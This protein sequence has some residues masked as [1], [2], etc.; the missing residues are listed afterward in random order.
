MNREHT[1]NANPL[2]AWPGHTGNWGRWPNDRGTLNL[3]TPEV[4]LRGIGCAR[5]GEVIHCARPTLPVGSI[6]SLDLFEQTMTHVRE[7]ADDCSVRTISAADKLT[8]RVHN[9]DNTH[10]D[11]L[12]HIGFNGRNFNGYRNTDVV[13]MKD[14][15]SKLDVTSALSMVTRGKLI[16]VA[17]RRGVT[18]LEPG[19]VVTPNDIAETVGRI[20][21]GDAVLIRT[22]ATLVGGRHSHNDERGLW[23]GIHP[24]CVEL[25]AERDISVIGADATEPGPSPLPN[26][27]SRPF[28]VMCLT[29]YGIHIVHSMDLERL[30]QRCAELQRED[31]L[32]MAGALFVPKATG[33][34]LTPMAV[35]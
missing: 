11:A 4:V 2:G 27:C 7:V 23:S 6:D 12:S 32:F 26:Q 17:R 5:L 25:L 15:A 1:D 3:I 35:L 22:G 31:F 29:V 18:Y 28:H 33:S 19:D 14:G 9:L 10:I 34:P 24:E 30:A 13:N 16:D 8:F 21:P 20:E